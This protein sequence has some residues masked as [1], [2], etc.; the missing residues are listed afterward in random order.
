MTKIP[1][2]TNPWDAIIV[3][4]NCQISSVPIVEGKKLV[5]SFSDVD[6]RVRL[7]GVTYLQGFTRD[8]WMLLRKPMKN[9]SDFRNTEVHKILFNKSVGDV[10]LAFSVTGAHTL[11]LVDEEGV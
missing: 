1:P 9:F 8:N 5:G 6:L 10:V 11:F 7:I 3:L 4:N 2:V